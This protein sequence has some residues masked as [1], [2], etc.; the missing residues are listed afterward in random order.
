VFVRFPNPNSKGYNNTA[1]VGINFGYEVQIDEFGAPD[2]A[3]KHITGAIYNEDNQTF[4]RKP[5]KPAGQWNDYEIR[6]EGQ[7]YTVLLNGQQT[8][9]FTNTNPNRGLPSAPNAPSF[10]G[11]QGHFGSRVAFRNIR[12][13]QLP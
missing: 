4:T 3:D 13:K 7:V 2:G 12:F 1:Y 5:A 6:V 11:L 9:K 8:T 10:I